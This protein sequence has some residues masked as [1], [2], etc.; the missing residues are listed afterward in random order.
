M[1]EKILEQMVD[2]LDKQKE[3]LDSENKYQEDKAY[4][5]GIYIFVS[6]D[7]VNSTLFKSRHMELWPGFISTFYETVAEEFAVGRYRD[8]FGKRKLEESPLG[9][10]EKEVLLTGGFQLWKLED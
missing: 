7:L 2:S 6:F 1:N 10:Y 9:G 4:I 5:E 3:D 8:S